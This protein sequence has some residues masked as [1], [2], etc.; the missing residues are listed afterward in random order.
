MRVYHRPDGPPTQPQNRS[1][2]EPPPPP[3]GNI[4]AELRD[5]GRLEDPE[6]FTIIFVEQLDQDAEIAV[7]PRN[8][9]KV[10]VHIGMSDGIVRVYL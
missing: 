6:Q 4:E 1:D 7:V 3:F 5:A 8:A 10:F 2:N 9:R